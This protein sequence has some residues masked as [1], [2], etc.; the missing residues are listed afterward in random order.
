MEISVLLWVLAVGLM[1]AGLAGTLLPVLPGVPL[2]LLGMFIAAWIG[3]FARIGPWTLAVL[4]LLTVL[5]VAL[6]LGP[7]R[8]VRSAWARA[9]RPSSGAARGHGGSECS[10]AC[11]A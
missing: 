7:R 5:A 6:D 4:A 8:L 9:V 11:P 2:M 3:H 10:S 1:L